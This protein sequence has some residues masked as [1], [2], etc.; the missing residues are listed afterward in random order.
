VNFLN[1]GAVYVTA[2]SRN[3]EQLWQTKVSDY[4]NHQAFARRRRLRRPRDRGG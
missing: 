4:V 2:R 3:G 1:A